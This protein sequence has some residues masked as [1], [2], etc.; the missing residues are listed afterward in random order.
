MVFER[1]EHHA[2]KV[3]AAWAEPTRETTAKKW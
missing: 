1:T 2:V 3:L